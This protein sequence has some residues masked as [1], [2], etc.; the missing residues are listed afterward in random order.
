LHVVIWDPEGAWWEGALVPEVE[1]A[2]HLR[3]KG[4]CL[5]PVVPGLLRV[6]ADAG[7]T[8]RAWGKGWALQTGG[9]Q[10]L[11]PMSLFA[12][13][14]VHYLHWAA[15][16]MPTADTEQWGN[17]DRV[18]VGFYKPIRGSI[19]LVPDGTQIGAFQGAIEGADRVDFANLGAP[20][21]AGGW[22][23]GGTCLIRQLQD[24]KVAVSLHGSAV[25]KHAQLRVVWGALSQTTS[26]GG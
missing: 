4:V 13:H 2:R 3:Q 1:M 24:A 15:R 12:M 16:L 25:G 8:K 18:G 10:P 21:E 6:A 20:D 7:Y 17:E 22:T 26:A 9:H 19:G 14:D 11:C 23:V 5:L